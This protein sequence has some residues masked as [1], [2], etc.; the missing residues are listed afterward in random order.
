[1]GCGLEGIGFLGTASAVPDNVVTNAD[2]ERM[3]DTSDEWIVSRT[4]IRERRIAD[5]NTTTGDL[6]L[7]AAKQIMEET[8]VK[9]TDLDTIILATITPDYVFPSTA[10]LIQSALGAEN[11]SAFDM[12]AGCTGFIY[13]SILGAS[14]IKA[15]VSK[16]VLSIG[17]ETLSK[18]TDWE[19]RGTCI[20]FADGAGC[21]LL[22]KVEEDCGILAYSMSA[23]GGKG[24]ELCM[25]A[26]GSRNPATLETVKARDHFIHMNGNEIFRFAVAVVPKEVYKLVSSAGIEIADIDYFL[27]HQA[28]YRIINSAR[29]RLKVPQEKILMNLDKYG[30]TSAASIPLLLDQEVKNGTIKRGD[31]LCLVGFG[32]G[33]TYG[34]LL[35][36]F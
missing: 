7:K 26:G 4:G 14:L 22:G 31:L 28:N 9:A 29:K 30:N 3:V 10:C 15:G 20:L 23:D 18:I 2:L 25:P 5:A 1:M 12:E 33:L 32:A 6:S 35:V 17:A 19:D 24:L 21:A 13:A 27:F 36:R 11:A 16:Y 8:G 34:G